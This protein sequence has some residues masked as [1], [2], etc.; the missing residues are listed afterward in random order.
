MDV[1]PGRAPEVAARVLVITREVVITPDGEP[2]DRFLRV[3]VHEFVRE[4]EKPVAVLELH[5][6]RP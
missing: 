6:A 3:A 4:E 5:L 1:Q 2:R